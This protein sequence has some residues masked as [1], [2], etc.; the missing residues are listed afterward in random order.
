MG[1]LPQ[2]MKI[3]SDMFK[4]EEGASQATGAWPVCFSKARVQACNSGELCAVG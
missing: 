4:T 1:S 2:T 3:F